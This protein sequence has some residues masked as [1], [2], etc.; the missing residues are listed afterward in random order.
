MASLRKMVHIFARSVAAR[1]KLISRAIVGSLLL[2]C[3]VL[4]PLRTVTA[5][6]GHTAQSVHRAPERQVIQGNNGWEFEIHATPMPATVGHMV[7]L[8]VWLHKD[9]EVFSGMTEIAIMVA[10]LEEGQ[11]VMATHI[12]ARQGYTAQSFQLYDGGLHTIAV[13]VRPVGGEASGWTPPTA[14]LSVDVVA[15]HPPLAVQSRM[16]AILLSVLVIGMVV[17]FFVPRTSH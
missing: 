7:H 10:N 6:G 11:R 16:M 2:C 14:V 5:H 13:T 9:G 15:V 1:E 8:I 3:G 17:G 4:A 12:L